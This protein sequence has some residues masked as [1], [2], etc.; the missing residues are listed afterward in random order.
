MIDMFIHP[1]CDAQ[2]EMLFDL[3][4][5][6]WDHWVSTTIKSMDENGVSRSGVCIMDESALRNKIFCK[7]IE[8][9]SVSKRLWFTL[10]VNFRTDD[11]FRSI[12]VAS[13]A[14]FKGITFH[15]YLQEI[16]LCDYPIISN[17]V[18]YANSLGMYAGLCTAFGSKKMYDFA[19]LPL[20]AEILKQNSNFPF[21]LYHSGGAR[22]LEA[23]LLC[24]MW[25]NL[26]L[27]TSFSLSY[28][29]NSSVEMD[30]AFSI[31][32]IGAHRFMFGSDAPFLP[33]KNAIRDHLIFFEK[34]GFDD[35]TRKLILGGSAQNLL[36]HIELGPP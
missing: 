7:H 18:S 12:R 10:M 34:Y 9:T 24:E 13:E 22:I 20:A 4:D 16:K 14:G 23:L 30:M 5:V 2:E 31:R 35:L 21:V 11:P 27:E 25:P 28:W 19:S 3:S 36:K 29:L 26:Y 8:A 17:I 1:R 6:Y 33:L 32:K 15:S